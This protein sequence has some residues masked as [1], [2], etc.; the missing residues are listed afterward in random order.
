MKLLISCALL[1]VSCSGLQAEPKPTESSIR[2][3]LE[4]TKA[5]RLV[6]SMVAQM[7]AAMKDGMVQATKGKP[8][9][10]ELKAVMDRVQKKTMEV[11]K[12]ELDWT[13]LEPLYVT[14][15]QEH[16]TQAEVDAMLT[17]YRTP[18]GA[19]VIEKLPVVMQ[20]SMVKMQNRMGPMLQKLETIQ[21]DMLRELQ[22][23]TSKEG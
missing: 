22:E 21:K 11:L 12:E 6:D 1:L 3:L 13:V 8:S 9:S 18:V 5:K 17:F 2:Q 7:D 19:T 20:Q 10:V 23:L 14:V 16:F 15:Y 4:V